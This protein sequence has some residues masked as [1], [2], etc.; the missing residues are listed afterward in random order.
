MRWPV[1]APAA[2]RELAR[3]AVRLEAV[4]RVLPYY[5]ALGIDDHAHALEA[6]AVRIRKR[7]AKVSGDEFRRNMAAR[8]A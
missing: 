3:Q 7:I 4:L 8:S 2:E 6:K 5:R 1:F